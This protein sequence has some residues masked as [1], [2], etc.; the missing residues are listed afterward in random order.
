MRQTDGAEI[1]KVN[2]CDQSGIERSANRCKSF[3][4]QRLE[5]RDGKKLSIKDEA[6]ETQGKRISK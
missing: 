1:S 5:Q 4:S 6:E 2:Q 3:S